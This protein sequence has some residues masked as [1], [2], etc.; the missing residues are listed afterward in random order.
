[1]ATVKHLKVLGRKANPDALHN[2]A[3]LTKL[4]EDIVDSVGMQLLGIPTVHDVDLDIAKLGREP[5]EDEGGTS[6]QAAGCY[7]VYGCLSTSHVAFHGWPMRQEW[8]LD[9]Y[10]CRPFEDAPIIELLGE[11]LGGQQQS[12]DLTFALAWQNGKLPAKSN[13]P[14]F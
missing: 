11:R 2:G 9:I 5:F 7:L 1:M 10:S 8:H 4:V 14:T 6:V 12:T 3:H 13:G